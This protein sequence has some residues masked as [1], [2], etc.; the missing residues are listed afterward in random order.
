MFMQQTIAD[1]YPLINSNPL[2]ADS[3]VSC[4]VIDMDVRESRAENL[5]T[6]LRQYESLREFA[7]RAELAAPHVS[8]MKNG[9]R[10]MGDE[11]ARRIEARLGLLH[12]WMDHPHSETIRL[13][14]KTA[15][16]PPGAI[17]V[18]WENLNDL[19]KDAY[20]HVPHYDV[21]LSAGDGTQWV[22]HADNSPLVFRAKWFAGRGL[23]P[24][25]C[26]ALYV[27]GDS[28]QPELKDGDT[29]LIDT[30]STT[31]RDDAVYALVYFDKLYIKRLFLLPGGGVELRSDNKHHPSREVHGA[32]LAQLRILGE[33]V[34]RA[35]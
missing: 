17:V 27:S 23:K 10:R 18:A 33:K 6:L 15:T 1:C 28:M 4:Y 35:G 26:R 16:A 24:E 2:I 25:N 21:E 12:G 3:V 7:E 19:P 9:V 13:T 5:V 11:V 14:P 22:E 34:W 32:D 20:V 8:Q 30:S 29:V 31:I